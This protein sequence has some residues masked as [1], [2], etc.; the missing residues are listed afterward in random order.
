M[1]AELVDDWTRS[2]G[3][4]AVLRCATRILP[5]TLIAC[6]LAA[7]VRAA[8]ESIQCALKVLATPE[9]G[10]DLDQDVKI[11]EE[12]H[13]IGTAVL[14]RH[15]D[16]RNQEN[17]FLVTAYHV[18][19]RSTTLEFKAGEFNLLLGTGDIEPLFYYNRVCDIA[20]FRLSTDGVDRVNRAA[21]A[22]HPVRLMQRPAANG[23]EPSLGLSA[24][25]VGN[26][27]VVSYRPEN[28]VYSCTVSEAVKAVNR[29]AEAIRVPDGNS[30]VLSAAND[31]TL[32]F[33][34]TLSIDKGFSGGPVV[35]F[36]AS[37]ATGVPKPQLVGVVL[38]GNPALVAGR[39]AFACRAQEV[40]DGI[41]VLEKDRTANEAQIEG[42]LI[43][44]TATAPEGMTMRWP[45]RIYDWGS[46]YSF[47]STRIVEPVGS[48][49]KLVERFDFDWDQREDPS[50]AKKPST[51]TAVKDHVVYLFD[52]VNF[53]RARFHG[54]DLSNFQFVNCIFEDVCFDDAVL[55][56]AVFAN[57]TFRLHQEPNT[58]GVFLD[59]GRPL[60]AYGVQ[61][62]GPR[63]ELVQRR[64]ESAKPV[65]PPAPES[66]IAPPPPVPAPAPPAAA[67]KEIEKQSKT[68]DK[69]WLEKPSPAPAV[70][71]V[72]NET[73]ATESQS[74]PLRVVRFPIRAFDSA[75]D[76]KRGMNCPGRP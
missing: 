63:Y 38:G 76:C 2:T 36:A 48:S 58:E 18:V 6:S 10:R 68:I 56:G 61:I 44:P 12:G 24:F 26:P 74:R 14:V 64:E 72:T 45:L 40:E 35:V 51:E 43:Y 3:L 11:T 17:F 41:E 49:K 66:T 69:F 13:V 65:P 60:M 9:R 39:F 42:T 62:R 52:R 31:L 53:R 29:I 21:N 70:P 37:D 15:T 32:L 22:L 73:A 34:E 59:F 57:C 8:Q 67:A 30:A 47:S 25:A 46:T 1:Y 19:Y 27:K 4:S 23:P 7:P 16:K 5:I 71:A 54:A 20:I 75:D 33:L 28:V 55:N 50:E